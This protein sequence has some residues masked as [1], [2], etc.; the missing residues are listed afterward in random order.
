[1]LDDI[2][3]S[4]LVNMDNDKLQITLE[5]MS[6]DELSYIDAVME[7]KYTAN[8]IADFQEIMRIQNAAHRDGWKNVSK[9]DYDRYVDIMSNTKHLLKMRQAKNLGREKAIIERDKQYIQGDSDTK[10]HI[11][12]KIDD[13]KGTNAIRAGFILG[14]PVGG[15]GVKGGIALAKAVKN[16]VRFDDDRNGLRK[17]GINNHPDEQ[18]QIN[19]AKNGLK[20]L[21]HELIKKR[22]IFPRKNKET[23]KEA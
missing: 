1:M 12:N 18:W 16:S 6:Y 8:D 9:E 14:G 2:L 10:S 22:Y 7:A 11:G 23:S 3:I 20:K 15:W 13:F 4:S 5:S 21:K 17:R 19:R